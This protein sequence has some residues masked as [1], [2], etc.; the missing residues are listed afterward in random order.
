MD[1][2]EIALI[3]S[4]VLLLVAGGY[5]TRGAK[6]YSEDWHLLSRLS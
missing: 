6:G 5:I 4:L 1:W 3:V 2:S